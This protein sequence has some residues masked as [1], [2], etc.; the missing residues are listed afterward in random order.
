M[1]TESELADVIAAKVILKF[2]ENDVALSKLALHRLKW[3]GPKELHTITGRSGAMIKKW[4]RDGT[5][6]SFPVPDQNG[7]IS[8]NSERRTTPKMWEE[9]ER[10]LIERGII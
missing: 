6:R 3:L 9:D 10:A 5:I 4:M 8:E 2:S 7:D 1:G